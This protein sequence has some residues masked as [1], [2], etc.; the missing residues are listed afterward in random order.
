MKRV[1][2]KLCCLSTGLSLVYART[3]H[4]RH[5]CTSSHD[6]FRGPGQDLPARTHPAAPGQEGQELHPA[7]G[8]RSR[9][10]QA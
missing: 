7:S 2:R 3:V 9:P 5:T 6:T 10:A 8:A 1:L 4:V